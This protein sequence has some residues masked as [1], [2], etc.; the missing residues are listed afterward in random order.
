[1]ITET[2]MQVLQNQLHDTETRRA[3]LKMICHTE[4]TVL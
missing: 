1:M 4:T 2:E 3:A